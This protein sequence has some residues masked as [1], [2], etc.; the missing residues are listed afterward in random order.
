VIAP[1]G[2][3]LDARA[4]SL[5]IDGPEWAGLVA[6]RPDRLLQ[7]VGALRR[8]AKE[9]AIDGVFV[10]NGPGH[11]AVAAALRGTGVPLF[12]VRAEI[13]QP[14]RGPLQRWL[15]SR[16]TAQVLISGSFMRGLLVERLGISPSAIR[17]LP[18][19]ID[20]GEADRIDRPQARAEVLE[21]TGWPPTSRIIGMLARYSPVKGHRDL[22]DA[23][24]VIASRYENARF[25]VA[26]PPGQT[27]RPKV[28]DWVREAGLASRFAVLEAL[29]DP[30]RV[31]GG[32]DVAV[33]ASR[34]SEAV[35]RSALEYMALGLPIV[36]TDVNVIPETL[37]EAGLLV[38]PAD[39]GALAQ[40]IDRLL[41]DLD[42]ARRCGEAAALRV[43]QRFELGGIAREAIGI[44][45]AARE[46]RHGND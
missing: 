15:Y 13:R 22:V 41:V 14:A 2:S 35:C 45:D 39:P 42:L 38:P 5:G 23:A 18:A 7:T 10:H 25:F 43:R 17:L 12:R 6:S 32:F 11:G 4:V 1:P 46:E 3:P 30:L 27:G 8:G 9:G 36:A 16:G 21:R 37:G 31:A 24:R 26:G 34:G 44:L 20:C 40:A 33:I 19:G 29:P 28:A